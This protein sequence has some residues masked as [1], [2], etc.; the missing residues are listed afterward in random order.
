MM[1]AM[2]LARVEEEKLLIIRRGSKVAFEKGGSSTNLS[3]SVT[4]SKSS[5]A[6]HSHQSN[7]PV[8]RL[9]PQEILEKRDKGLCFYCEEKYRSMLSATNVNHNKSS[10]WTFFQRW[11]EKYMSEFKRRRK[12]KISRPLLSFQ[13]V[14]WLDWWE[15][16]LQGWLGN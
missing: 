8:K 16:V 15:L 7:T 12:P 6:G 5:V 9:T 13:P 1:E 10:V 14:L 3:G 2:R 4:P 11:M